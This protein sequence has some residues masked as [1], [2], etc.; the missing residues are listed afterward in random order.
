M[1]NAIHNSEDGDVRSEGG[2]TTSSDKQRRKLTSLNSNSKGTL[3][4]KLTEPHY[5]NDDEVRG[6]IMKSTMGYTQINMG[7]LCKST[8]SSIM[9]VEL[10][11]LEKGATKLQ[12]GRAIYE[13]CVNMIVPCGEAFILAVKYNV[14]ISAELEK[15]SQHKGALTNALYDRKQA[16]RT[17]EKPDIAEMEGRVDLIAGKH[18]LTLQTRYKALF[19]VRVNTEQQAMLQQ[20]SPSRSDTQMSARTDTQSQGRTRTRSRDAADVQQPAQQPQ[21]QQPQAQ[22]QGQQ[23]QPADI[24]NPAL[25]ETSDEYARYKAESDAFRTK[26]RL[27]QLE[28][29]FKELDEWKALN[30]SKGSMEVDIMKLETERE[31]IFKSR[32]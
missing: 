24:G 18:D 4:D 9:Q 5:L 28:D 29:Y 11:K 22:Q 23:P 19:N 1:E 7:K 16:L 17:I 27:E 3:K 8:M 21:Q 31:R 15:L 25:W 26:T 12:I 30:R 13:F 20:A 6:F 10:Q 14:D 2:H 32:K